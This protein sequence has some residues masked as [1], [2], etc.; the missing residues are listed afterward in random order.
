MV[1]G[2]HLE[3]DNAEQA[4]VVRVGELRADHTLR[5]IAARLNEQG[6]RTRRGS[7]WRLE[8][9]ARVV[10]SCSLIQ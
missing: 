6:L 2:L 10:N 1:S 9:V 4:V 5:Q 7:P 8:S 3:P